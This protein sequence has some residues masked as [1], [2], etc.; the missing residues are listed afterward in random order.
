[1]KAVFFKIVF[2]PSLLILEHVFFYKMSWKTVDS[3]FCF[4]FVLPERV[5]F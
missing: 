1:M 5:N 2:F 3:S 4:L